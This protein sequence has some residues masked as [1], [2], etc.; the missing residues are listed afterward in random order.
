MVARAFFIAK[1]SYVNALKNKRHIML[2]LAVKTYPHLL[3]AI[4]K[5]GGMC[6]PV[7]RL[8]VS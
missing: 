4:Q 8:F 2:V 6:V 3:V 1:A 7:T 5:V